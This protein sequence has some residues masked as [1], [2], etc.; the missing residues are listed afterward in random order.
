L[1]NDATILADA[2]K[3]DLQRVLEFTFAYSCLSASW[4]LAIGDD[5]AA[6]WALTIGAILEPHLA[7]GER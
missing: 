2:L 6:Q 5:D 3:I 7:L 1:L 4:S